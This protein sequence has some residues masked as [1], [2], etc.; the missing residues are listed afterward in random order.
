MSRN[1]VDPPTPLGSRSMSLRRNGD[2]QVSPT[3]EFSPGLLDLHSFDT[4]LLPEVCSHF[5]HI[6]FTILSYKSF[7]FFFFL[8]NVCDKKSRLC[9]C[10]A[11]LV[12][13]SRI[14]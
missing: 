2:D 3:S 10:V 11:L 5:F 1:I 12:V 13:F 14:G 9:N 6:L 4:E 8:Q 7:F